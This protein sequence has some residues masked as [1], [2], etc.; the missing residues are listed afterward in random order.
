MEVV[1]NEAIGVPGSESLEQ[2]FTR[3]MQYAAELHQ[4]HIDDHFDDIPNALDIENKAVYY[5]DSKIKIV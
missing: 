5:S 4:K 2:Y 3:L 1:G